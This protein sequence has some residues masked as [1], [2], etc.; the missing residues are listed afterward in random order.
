[1]APEAMA[2]DVVLDGNDALDHLA[3]TRYDVAVLDR[4][5]PEVQSRIQMLTAA[6]TVKERVHRPGA[7][8]DDY[9]PKP[10]DFPN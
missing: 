3:V 10:F 4:D 1:M 9:L 5:L 2:A 8:A 6:R 7:G